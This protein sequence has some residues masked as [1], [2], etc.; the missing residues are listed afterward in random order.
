MTT[1]LEK[2]A[3][4]IRQHSGRDDDELSRITGIRPRQ[5]VN[6]EARL[7]ENRGLVR[8]ETGP[9]DKIVNNWIAD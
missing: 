8:R 9:R 3:E 1:N 5:T 4:A 6:Q 2:V 7:L